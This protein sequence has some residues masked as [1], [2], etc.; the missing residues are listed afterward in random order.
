MLATSFIC[1]YSILMSPWCQ[2]EWMYRFTFKPC[3]KSFQKKCQN[4]MFDQPKPRVMNVSTTKSCQGLSSSILTSQIH[5]L[6]NMCFFKPHRLWAKNHSNSH[7]HGTVLAN[8]LP[9]AGQENTPWSFDFNVYNVLD[10]LVGL[11]PCRNN[12]AHDAILV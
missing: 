12:M 8:L 7:L 1:A 2:P 6:P 10:Q 4:S 5:Y 11:L 3:R 9:R